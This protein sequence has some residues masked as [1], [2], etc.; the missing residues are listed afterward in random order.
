MTAKQKDKKTLLYDVQVCIITDRHMSRGRSFE[1]VVEA[2]IRG[3]AQMIQFR[4]KEI[5][6]GQFY[7]EALKLRILTQKAGVLF[8]VNDRVDVALS[9][10][11]DGVIWESMIS[12]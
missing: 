5:P 4:D 2:A 6:N 9:V 3:G 1:E 7:N 11:A 8:M 12:P 10:G